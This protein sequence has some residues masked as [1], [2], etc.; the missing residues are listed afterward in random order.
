MPGGDVGGRGAVLAKGLVRLP[1]GI[2]ALDGEPAVVRSV[3]QPEEQ[4]LAV[5][6][7]RDVDRKIDG[8]RHARPLIAWIAVAVGQ[9]AQPVLIED[10]AVG[11]HGEAKARE[12]AL[13]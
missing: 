9:I 10:R 1:V 7:R 12:L 5:R 2:E 6:L 8:D 13:E 4:L 3:R 11:R